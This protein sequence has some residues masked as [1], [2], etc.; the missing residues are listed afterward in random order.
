RGS[1]IRVRATIEKFDKTMLI[2]RDVPYGSTTTALMDSIVKASENNK[3]KVK[4]VI[5]NTAAD[6]E[7]Q[8]HLPAGVSPDLTIDALYAFTDCEVAIS[9][10]T[11]VIINDKPHFLS[12]DEL[13]RM[14]TFKTVDLLKRELEIRKAEL[15]DKWHN[16]SLEK[17]FIENRIYRDIEECETWE[18]VLNAIDK[19]LDPFKPLLR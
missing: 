15:E 14:S 1:R 5:D 4:K 16:S 17:I 10:N 19:G 6:V 9:P 12:V 8:V 11:C 18:A 13:L 2:I 7:I 3:I